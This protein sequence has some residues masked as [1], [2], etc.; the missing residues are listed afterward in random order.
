MARNKQHWHLLFI[1]QQTPHILIAHIT[2]DVSDM[3][4]DLPSAIQ[5]VGGQECVPINIG[6]LC[7][8][9]KCTDIRVTFEV[10]TAAG[11]CL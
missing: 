1:H 4:T 2:A 10:A 8:L 9:L 11:G 3:V 6:G 5:R 7:N